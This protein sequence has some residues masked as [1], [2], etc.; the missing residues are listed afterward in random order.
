MNQKDEI[1]SAYEEYISRL[2]DASSSIARIKAENRKFEAIQFS[3]LNTI[4]TLLEDSRKQMKKVMEGTVWDRLV[5]AFFGETNAGKSTIIESF[6]I[7]FHDP[8]RAQLIKEN[9]GKG[10]DGRIVGT[11]V[12]DFTKVYHEYNLE[13]NGKP[14]V[15]VDVPGIEGKEED[16]EDEILNALKLAHCVFFVHGHN[17]D[18]E[19]PIV[20][21][22]KRYLSDWV[23][24]YSIYNVRTGMS[25]FDEEDE[26]IDLMTPKRSRNKEDIAATFTRVL[27]EAY[28]GDFAIQAALAL[29]A[30]ADFDE[31]QQELRSNQEK[32]LRYFG[33]SEKLLDFSRFREVISL[34]DEKAESFS[35]IILQANRLKL[36]G[37]K[38]RIERSVNDCVDD[39]KNKLEQYV[40]QIRDFK[41]NVKTAFSSAEGGIKRGLRFE[42]SQA[43][44][45]V[46]RSANRII[47]RGGKTKEQRA[48]LKDSIDRIITELKDNLKSVIDTSV[49]DLKNTVATKKKDLDKAVDL[50]QFNVTIPDIDSD[51]DVDSIISEMDF[52]FFKDALLKGLFSA[53]ATSGIVGTGMAVGFKIGGSVGGPGGA[54]IGAGVGGVVTGLGL[55]AKAVFGKSDNGVD[56]AKLKAQEQVDRE[57]Q[58]LLL[59][60]DVLAKKVRLKMEPSRIDLVDSMDAEIRNVEKIKKQISD[61]LFFINSK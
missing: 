3:Y 39:N 24:V 10:V 47:D 52:N 6:R 35:S 44:D 14:F 17:K 36:D 9:G 57:K 12:Q 33:S 4:E 46:L 25:A 54:A 18:I 53:V 2:N 43:M 38:K 60:M 16:Y 50:S 32:A 26:R 45:A 5:I 11:G 29:S 1:R 30:V 58:K 27:G 48:L 56:K 40:Q 19:A 7:L 21:K 59:K 28:R 15:L 55:L 37:L 8:E 41:R 13:I 20:E 51:I 23:E 61:L 42:A 31:N 22:I 34:V 49:Q